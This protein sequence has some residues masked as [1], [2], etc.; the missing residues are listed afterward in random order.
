MKKL[1]LLLLC[2]TLLAIPA[3][4]DVIVGI[5]PD[6]GSGNCFPFGCSYNAEYQQ[7]YV[8][9]DFS[10]PITITNLEFFN[11]QFN[12]F[13]TSTPTGTFTISLSTTQAGLNTMSPDF[14]ANIGPDNTQV[15][16]G[17]IFQSWAFGD[18]LHIILDHP[19]TY[20]PSKGNLLMDVMGTNV[21][22][23]GGSIFFDVNST[24]GDFSRVYC[25]SGIFCTVGVA[26]TPGYG[27][28]T[29]FST[30]TATPEPASLL[31]LGSGLVGLAGFIRRKR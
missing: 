3:V 26:D 19:F 10:G 24:Q 23:S 29:G 27:L 5:P 4:A 11:T 8:S 18:T 13:A 28:V 17:S 21:N 6:P 15:F 16:S 12:N 7:V 25:P 22:A 20:D 9:S 14:A 30:G 31:L 1:A 2:F